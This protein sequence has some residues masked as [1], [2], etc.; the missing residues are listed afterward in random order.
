MP[1]FPSTEWAAA[2]RDAINQNAAY[3]EA[4]AAW[5]GDILLEVVGDAP[6]AKGAGVYLDLAHGQCREARYVAAA[7]EV[8]PEFTFRGTRAAWTRIFRK[9]VDPIRAYLDGTI[10][11]VGNPAKVLRFARAAKELIETASNVP[12]GG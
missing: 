8:N 7:S 11:L 3:A 4:A 12:S 10:K 5:E 6:S 1:A 2:F 9:E